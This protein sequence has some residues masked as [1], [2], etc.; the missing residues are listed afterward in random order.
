MDDNKD[1]T[2]KFDAVGGMKIAEKVSV[3]DTTC[4]AGVKSLK[5]GRLGAWAPPE[6][7]DF[8]KDQTQVWV[9]E[10]SAE[11]FSTINEIL[12]MIGQTQYEAMLNKGNYKAQIDKNL[13]SSNKDDPSAAGQGS[14]NQSS[15]ST[16]PN[17][18]MWTVNSSRVDNNS[19]PY[20]KAWIHERKEGHGEEPGKL[21][22]AK[23]VITEPV[24]ETNQ[25]A[26]FTLSFKMFPEIDGTVYPFLMGKGL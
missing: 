24:T 5:I 23:V 7:S 16:A 13:C 1:I 26:I 6:G 2:V 14:Q 10:R 8:Q 9:S 20:L 4:G 12:C 22:S 18:M 11:T 17:Y 3:V 21:I 15:G 25:Y 19:P